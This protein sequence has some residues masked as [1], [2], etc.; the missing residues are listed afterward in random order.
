MSQA[1]WFV[2]RPADLS[3]RDWDELGAV[4]DDGSGDTHL[5]DAL[6]VEILSLLM[7]QARSVQELAAQLV[8]AMPDDM[9]EAV[10]SAFI[11]R[12]LHGL[13]DLGLVSPPVGSA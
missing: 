1:L 4:Y 7:E 11:E 8:E 3:W 5:I 10:A 9:S 2:R 13:Q 6:G 12:Q